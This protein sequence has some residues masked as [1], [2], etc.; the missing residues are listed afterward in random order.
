MLRELILMKEDRKRDRIDCE[1][2]CRPN[3]VNK[4]YEKHKEIY[5]PGLYNFKLPMG[6]TTLSF[7]HNNMPDQITKHVE[8]MTLVDFFGHFGGVVG[9]WLGFSITTVISDLFDIIR[10]KYLKILTC[11]FEFD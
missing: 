1:K 8:K 7:Y 2:K 6:T 5:D 11:Q 3:C 4:Y 10:R 9:L